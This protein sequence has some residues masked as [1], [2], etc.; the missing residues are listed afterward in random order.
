MRGLLK[1]RG[2]TRRLISRYEVA[3]C[4]VESMT[5]RRRSAL[6]GGLIGSWL[7]L[8]VLKALLSRLFGHRAQLLSFLS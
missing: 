1:T 6:I 3:G 7:A 8:S 4:S 5:G 2:L